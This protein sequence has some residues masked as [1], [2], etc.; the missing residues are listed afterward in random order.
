MI[1]TTRRALRAKASRPVG[2]AP[3]ILRLLGGLVLVAMVAAGVHANGLYRAL[4]AKLAALTLAPFSKGTGSSGDTFYLHQKGGL[5]GLQI[6][7]E[8]TALILIAP[9]V[10][11]A[12]VLLVFTRA[13]VWRIGAGLALMWVTITAVNEARLA[14]IGFSSSTWGIDLG[15]TISHTYVGSVIGIFGFVA[16]LAALL[17]TTGTVRRTRR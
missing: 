16:G 2:R 6:T 5:I 14:L 4:E 10:V 9:L 11:L 7:S 1:T 3:R 17:L 13:R 12:A 8:C 15:Y